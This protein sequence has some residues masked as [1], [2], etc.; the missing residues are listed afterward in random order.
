MA[1]PH[2]TASGVVSESLLVLVDITTDEGVVGHSIVFTFPAAT[3]KPMASLIQNLEPLIQGEPLAPVTIELKLASTFRLMG[4]QGLIGMA[5]AGID[6]ALWDA[7]ARS[8]EMPLARLLGGVEKPIPAYGG[9]GHDGVDGSARAAAAWVEQGLKGV[10]AKIGYPTVRE[11]L[12]VIRAIRKA[13]GEG[14]SVMVDYNQ[15]LSPTEAIERIRVLDGEGLD[16]VEE[17]T[18]AHDHAGHAQIARAVKTPIQYGENWWGLLDV[19]EALKPGVV[20][21]IMPDVMKIGGVSAWLR[22]AAMAHAAGVRVSSHL[23]PEVSAHLLGVAQSSHWLEYS[24]WWNPILAEPLRLQ[25]GMA[26]ISD[27]LGTGV[28][29][30][31]KAVARYLA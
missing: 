17:P 1:H 28:A 19:R 31:E 7:L 15:C 3:L 5:M 26:D 22:A 6:M 25:N 12:A 21:Y 9:V 27:V 11:D 10:K 13:V 30:D 18:L 14:V 24:D 4:T 20:G 8:Y 16:W 2:R 23:W 29:W